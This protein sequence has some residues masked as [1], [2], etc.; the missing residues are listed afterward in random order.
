MSESVRLVALALASALGFLASAALC[1]LLAYPVVAVS[2]AAWGCANAW[3]A[4]D[5]FDALVPLGFRGFGWSLRLA[6]APCLALALCGAARWALLHRRDTASQNGA[7]MALGTFAEA[8]AKALAGAVVLPVS[9]VKRTRLRLELETVL[10]ASGDCRVRCEVFPKGLLALCIAALV[11]VPVVC[12]LAIPLKRLHY[13]EELLVDPRV[14]PCVVCPFAFAAFVFC[15]LSALW[16]RGRTPL[17]HPHPL[18]SPLVDAATRAAWLALG[19]VGVLVLVLGG[20]SKVHRPV[21]SPINKSLSLK[22]VTFNVR[23]PAD[24]DPEEDLWANRRADF[25]AEVTALRP[26]VFAMQEVYIWPLWYIQQHVAGGA[27]S[28]TGKGR[29]DGV[30]AGE[31]SVIFFNHT[32]FELMDG[33][34][35]WLSGTPVLPSKFPNEDRWNNRVA[36]W[37]RLRER[38]TGVQFFVLTAHWGWG[39]GFDVAATRLILKEART[40][41]GSLPVIVMGD[42]NNDVRGA[43]YPLMTGDAKLALRDAMYA[44]EG[45]RCFRSNCTQVREWRSDLYCNSTLGDTRIDHAFVS[46]SVN[47][48][49]YEVRRDVR[50][51]NHTFS[52]HF[53]VAF[54]V[55]M[56][57]PSRRLMGSHAGEDEDHPVLRLRTIGL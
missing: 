21:P 28:W 14:L 16:S 5:L 27:F 24:Y 46:E 31:H 3:W 53:P 30:H 57:P 11:V 56:R 29:D 13:A 22:L 42:F 54:D 4:E 45:P 8:G 32:K 38:A 10:N 49:Y 6:L 1:G 2:R 25:C 40:Y 44:C 26:D 35:L 36:T 23:Y 37:A 15:A 33:D 55:T 43:W 19:I 41:S 48:T 9:A 50:P 20:L 34:T 51:N 17:Y 47:V 52:D 18:S 7:R 39:D 12:L